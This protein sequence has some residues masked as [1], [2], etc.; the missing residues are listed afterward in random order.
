MYRQTD[1]SVHLIQ[2][3]TRDDAENK[4]ESSAGKKAL[5]QVGLPKNF[6]S[7]W[8]PDLAGQPRPAAHGHRCDAAAHTARGWLCPAYA[9]PTMARTSTRVTYVASR[10]PPQPGSRGN[11]PW[12][13]CCAPPRP[14]RRRIPPPPRA[15]EG[16]STSAGTAG[17]RLTPGR[18][19]RARCWNNAPGD[20][21]SVTANGDVVAPFIP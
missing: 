5:R 9:R 16:R 6:L 14:R 4:H 18:C 3:I 13:P 21:H 1:G 8:S 17:C 20:R 2:R 7:L 12:A 15:R 11:A 19:C 10:W